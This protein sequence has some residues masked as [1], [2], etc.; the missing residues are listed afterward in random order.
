MPRWKQ[1]LAG[2]VSQFARLSHITE[3]GGLEILGR[4]AI[5]VLGGTSRSWFGQTRK[6]RKNSVHVVRPLRVVRI[7][8]QPYEW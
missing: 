4:L 2:R 6:W 1:I 7:E 8:A 3:W 5:G